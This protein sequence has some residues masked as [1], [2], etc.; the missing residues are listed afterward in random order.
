MTKRAVLYGRVSTDEQAEKGFSLQSQFEHC[1]QYAANL[2]YEVV[3]EIQD[4]IS[5]VKEKRPGLDRVQEMITRREIDTVI[6]FSPD[7]LTRNLGHSVVLRE[8]WHKAGVELHYCNRG[9]LENTA[10]GKMTEN[11]EAVFA[12]YWRE[13]IIESSAR[14]RRTKAANGKWP[15]DGTA[16]YGYERIGI[17]RDVKLAILKPE[18][19]IVNRIFDLYVGT[20]GTPL[21]MQTIATLLTA[22]GIPP[23]NRGK[24]KGKSG[25]G[26]GWYKGTIRKL[27]SRKTYI[28]KLKYGTQE[29]LL[30]ELRIIDDETFAAAQER[31][32]GSRA[33]SRYDERKYDY[34][35]TGYFVCSCGRN[36]ATKP[37]QNGKYLYYQCGS[38]LTGR[39]LRQCQEKMVDAHRADALVWN[40]LTGVL[41]NEENLEKG[42]KQVNEDREKGLTEKRERLALLESL[43]SDAER[44]VKRLVKAF[45]EEDDD[46]IAEALRAEM[47]AAGRIKDALVIEE[48]V[49]RIE[50]EQGLLSE[51]D[52]QAI[53]A[54]ARQ[55]R[56]NLAEPDFLTKRAVMHALEVKVELVWRDGR[57]CLKCSCNLT[58]NGKLNGMLTPILPGIPGVCTKSSSTTTVS[59]RICLS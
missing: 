33:V 35:L 49:L 10:E 16:S 36:M 22:E 43:V 3:A 52:L 47:K 55:I 21:P 29:I 20:T 17:K 50:I 18:A 45:S 11:I 2:G 34:L 5:G 38:R 39:H 57:R 15:G 27:L 56:G 46:L 30:P 4:E 41:M 14:G 24:S 44:K 9:K 53:T 58:L 28:G 42:L 31:L 8:V 7:R 6:V 59:P 51:A 48:R 32:A 1:R 37:M 25:P 23:P 40:W 19:E 26:K 12:E 54:M 13:K